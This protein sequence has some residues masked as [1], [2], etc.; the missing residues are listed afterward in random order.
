M[1]GR[2]EAAPQRLQ[3]S[4]NKVQDMKAVGGGGRKNGSCGAKELVGKTQEH[5]TFV[6]GTAAGVGWDSVVR[7]LHLPSLNPH[8]LAAGGGGRA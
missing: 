4:M 8:A 3:I 6:V 7:L 5:P 2:N 1:V